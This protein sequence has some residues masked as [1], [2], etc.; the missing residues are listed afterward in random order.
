MNPQSIL[1]PQ[2]SSLVLYTAGSD[3]RTKVYL[4]L[5]VISPLMVKIIVVLLFAQ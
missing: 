4:F 5:N 2:K 1:L 3:Y